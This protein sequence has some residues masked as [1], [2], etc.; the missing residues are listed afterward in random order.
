MFIFTSIGILCRHAMELQA[1]FQMTLAMI[2]PVLCYAQLKNLVGL[3][4]KCGCSFKFWVHANYLHG[5]Q[6]A[7]RLLGQ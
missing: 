1:V 3:H 7:T 6:F 4:S 2:G 5:L